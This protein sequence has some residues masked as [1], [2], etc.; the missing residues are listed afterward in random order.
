MAKNA[1]GYLALI[2][3]A[4]EEQQASAQ[5]EKDARE[6]A[7]VL[8]GALNTAQRDLVRAEGKVADSKS[9]NP[10][11]PEMALQAVLEADRIETNVAI[12]A[13]LQVELFG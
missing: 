7:F 13:N 1:T 6:A 4:G 2:T 5:R 11:N 12:L 3:P 8:N 10:F 9:A